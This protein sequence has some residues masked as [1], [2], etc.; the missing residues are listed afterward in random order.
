M[1][2]IFEQSIINFIISPYG[3]AIL[4]VAIIAI[5]ALV[6]VNALKR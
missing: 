2:N 1:N 6:I 4:L 3:V 5:V